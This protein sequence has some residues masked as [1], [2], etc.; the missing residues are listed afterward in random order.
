MTAAITVSIL[1]K[2]V[3]VSAS[4]GDIS[5]AVVVSLPRTA[6][7]STATASSSSSSKVVVLEGAVDVNLV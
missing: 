7:A 5:S 6:A 3:V 4:I 2:V 1:H